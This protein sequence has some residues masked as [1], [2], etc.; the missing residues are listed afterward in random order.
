MNRF[1][2]IRV[3][4]GLALATWMFAGGWIGCSRGGT[5]DQPQAPPGLLAQLPSTTKRSD[6][7][8]GVAGWN[9]YLEPAGFRF[10]GLDPNGNKIAVVKI[11][12]A[13]TGIDL[14]VVGV[15]TA[16]RDSTGALAGQEGD[17]ASANAVGEELLSDL[18]A[19]IDP[20]TRNGMGQILSGILQDP[21]MADTQLQTMQSHLAT[22]KPKA[23]GA[24]PCT[25]GQDLATT[26]AETTLVIFSCGAPVLVDQLGYG[27]DVKLPANDP[28]T[29]KLCA[30][31]AGQLLGDFQQ[32]RSQ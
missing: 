9:V 30:F 15:A 5:I 31:S 18:I 11:G 7:T 25:R 4:G 32:C 1:S 26:M 23:D 14:S 2:F 10:D 16:H 21:T 3:A 12:Y 28:L 19:A 13:Q 22:L 20:D 6:G 24:N 17:A 27:F 29:A 8:P